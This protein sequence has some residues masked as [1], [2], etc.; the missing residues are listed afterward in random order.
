MRRETGTAPRQLLGDTAQIYVTVAAG[1]RYAD[2]EGLKIEE[3]RK[4]LTDLLIDAK[5]A[6][7]G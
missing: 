3:A 4:E 5:D 6:G 2:H 7:R 1:Q